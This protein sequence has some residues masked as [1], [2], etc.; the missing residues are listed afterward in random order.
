M[1][2]DNLSYVTLARISWWA[3]IF[4]MFT[5]VFYSQRDGNV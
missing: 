3:E 5:I 1:N 4:D 2:E